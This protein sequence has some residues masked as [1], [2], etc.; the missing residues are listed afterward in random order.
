VVLAGCGGKAQ[1]RGGSTAATSTPAGLVLAN[2]G[3]DLPVPAAT[4]FAFSKQIDYGTTYNITVKTQP[5]T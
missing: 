2:G 5:A 3:D 4:S 1:L